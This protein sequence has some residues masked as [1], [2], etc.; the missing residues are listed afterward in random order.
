MVIDS[1]ESNYSIIV[2]V[3]TDL[4]GKKPHRQVGVGKVIATGSLGSVMVREFCSRCNVCHLHHSDNTGAVT[5]IL[6]KL[7]TV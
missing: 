3:C 7:Y 5:R 6:Y 4:S 1:S 2:V